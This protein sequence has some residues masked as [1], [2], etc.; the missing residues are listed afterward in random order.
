MES[1][2]VHPDPRL[3]FDFYDHSKPAADRIMEAIPTLFQILQYAPVV[4]PVE[5]A[6][7]T[8]VEV[9]DTELRQFISAEDIDLSLDYDC[10]MAQWR[11]GRRQYYRV[12]GG[13]C[14]RIER[15]VG[16][17][18]AFQRSGQRI[19]EVEGDSL[20]AR[21]GV[22]L[23]LLLER[24]MFLAGATVQSEGIYRRYSRVPNALAR[25]ISYRLGIAPKTGDCS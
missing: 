4:D 19:V 18:A 22:A 10:I 15:E 7:A 1:P 20:L 6:N 8:L 9:Y 21:S 5:I 2:A 13:I 25:Q 17:C 24:S 23:P 14:R 16:I 12:S 11:F 3:Y